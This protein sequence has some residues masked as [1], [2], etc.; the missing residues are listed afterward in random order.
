LP[1]SFQ[2]RIVAVAITDQ[3]GAALRPQFRSV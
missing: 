1:V 3:V 2:R